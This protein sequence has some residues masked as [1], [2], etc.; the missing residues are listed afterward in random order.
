MEIAQLR[1]LLH[2]AELGSLSKAAD[3][4]GLA[5]PGLSRQIRA[6]ETELKVRLFDRHGRGMVLTETGRR[7]LISANAI[8]DEVDT[9]RQI[10]DES[11]VSFEGC[12]RFGMTPTVAEIMTVP[13]VRQIKLAHPGISLCISSAFSG[14]VLDWL[15][16]DLLD[17]C[18]SYDNES[19]GA[20][21][22][23][24]I[25]VEKLLLVGN[26][27]RGLRMDRPVSFSSLKDEL[28]ILPSPLHGLRR[29]IDSCAMRAGVTL[30]PHIEADSLNGMI[31]LVLGGLGCTVLPLAPIYSRIAAGELT[32][33]PLVDPEPSRHVVITYPVDRP[34]SPATR[35]AVQV[36]ASIAAK[37]VKKGIWKGHLVSHED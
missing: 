18:V 32:S 5:Q 22:S 20:V 7:I 36:F 11:C 31:D 2:V 30:S 34:V 17:C 10:A 27:A 26:A 1:T 13:L 28:L 29:N 37:L 3:H 35:F 6:L 14:H 9:I 4:V 12:V 15:K 19:A 8:L 16:R 33:C 21:R 25:L 24:P 23:R